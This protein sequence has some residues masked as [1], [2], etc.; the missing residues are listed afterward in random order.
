M[1][2]KVLS[3]ANRVS[4][5]DSWTNAELAELYRVDHVLAQAGIVVETDFGATDEG[6]P[7]FVFCRAGGEV[8]V[9]ATR[10]DG[11]YRLYSPALPQPLIGRSFAALARSFVS[12]LRKPLQQDATVSI[13]PAALLSVLIAAIFYSSDFYLSSA[14][15]AEAS[16]NHEKTVEQSAHALTEQ[17]RLPELPATDTLFHIVVAS[18]KTLLEPIAMSGFQQLG[19]LAAVENMAAAAVMALSSLGDIVLYAKSEL[20]TATVA[21]NHQCLP[22]CYNDVLPPDQANQKGNLQIASTAADPATIVTYAQDNPQSGQDAKY[23]L[24][25]PVDRSNFV[26]INSSNSAPSPDSSWLPITGHQTTTDSPQHDGAAFI[27]VADGSL[28]ILESRAELPAAGEHSNDAAVGAEITLGNLD[29][30]SLV[31]NESAIN[32][33]LVQGGGSIDLPAA[34]GFNQITVMGDGDLR[35]NGITSIDNPQLVV[36]AGFTQNVS[37]FFASAV[38]V[39]FVIR[40]EGNDTLSLTG[41]STNAA[42]VQMIIDSEG[43]AANTVAISDAATT[44]ASKLDIKLVGVQNLVLNES[45]TAF[46]KTTID[47]SGLSGGLTVGLDLSNALQWVDLSQVNATNFI[48]GNNGDIALLNAASGAHIQLSSDLDALNVTLAGATA[49]V[50]GSLA[51]SLQTEVAGPLAITLLD[52]IYTAYL[53]INSTN[54]GPSGV[55]TIDNLM[56]SSLS[57]LTITG[58]SALAVNSINGFLAGDS[59]SVTI[60]AHALTGSLTLDVSDIADTT[61]LGRSIT[62]V[63]GSG[64]NILTNDTISEN[65]AFVVG[66]GN[67]VIN[68]GGGA[69]KDSIVDLRATD[70]VNV[71]SATQ[72]DVLVNGVTAGTGQAM[73]NE[74]SNLIAAAQIASG[75]AGS[76]ATHQAVLFSYQDSLYVFVDAP[77]NHLFNSSY[78]AIIKLVGVA[79]TA[80]LT[81]VFHS[82]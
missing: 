52:T 12:V 48:V 34:T 6:D 42:S 13:H 25:L 28:I 21:G 14:K 56:D 23:N 68:I 43:S 82:A 37:L 16:A 50:P 24:P 65:T 20:E 17:H 45:A 60:D 31:G 53:S 8:V 9:H 61:T 19:F 30:L 78:D 46:G 59:H 64:Y 73:I 26:A 72:H 27:T 15:A 77:G 71:G 81:N 67:D 80:D 4:D 35:I 74:Q 40:L 11:F 33:V 54:A 69:I 70:I 36:G 18:I 62:I 38:P 75:L 39:P 47:S 5:R 2:S 66:A 57:T 79:A 58:D 29:T 1:T 63:G 44:G 51:L 32:I 55:N 76:S 3:F 41:I 7:W 22:G 10:F 49:A